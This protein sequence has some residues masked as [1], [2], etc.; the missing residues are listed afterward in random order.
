MD[1]KWYR[2]KVMKPDDKDLFGDKGHF[3]PSD[4][5]RIVLLLTKETDVK[6]FFKKTCLK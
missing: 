1:E 2:S 3:Y 4:K 5:Y 6:D